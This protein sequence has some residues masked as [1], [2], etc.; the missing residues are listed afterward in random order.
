[1]QSCPSAY[2]VKEAV[3]AC[4]F[5]EEA[6]PPF[7]NSLSVILSSV[8][9]NVASE[10]TLKAI[11]NET[12][13]PEGSNVKS[14]SVTPTEKLESVLLSLSAIHPALGLST[15]ETPYE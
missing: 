12:E 7:M 9:P 10:R 2:T 14:G 5:T 13:L 1:M 3:A 8:A 15:M 11:L 6:S 4:H